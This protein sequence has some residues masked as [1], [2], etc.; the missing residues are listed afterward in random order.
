MP[1][2]KGLI[3]VDSAGCASNICAILF[4]AGTER[5]TSSANDAK[6]GSES[7]WAYGMAPTQASRAL[8]TA[9][10]T[11]TESLRTHRQGSTSG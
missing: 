11:R 5:Q 7:R 6:E 4:S 8:R 1:H 2:L 3:V 10:C 9:R